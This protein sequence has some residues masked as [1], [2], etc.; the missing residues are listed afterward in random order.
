MRPVNS[1]GYE[2]TDLSLP[3]ALAGITEKKVGR[4]GPFDEYAAQMLAKWEPDSADI[5]IAAAGGRTWD[6]D[7]WQA[8]TGCASHDDLAEAI[9]RLMIAYE[10][11]VSPTR[12]RRDPIGRGP[13]SRGPIGRELAEAELLRISRPETENDRGLGR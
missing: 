7:T 2:P 12:S 6:F 9:H 4:L 5:L 3:E 1:Q 13:I 10:L 11:P 8:F